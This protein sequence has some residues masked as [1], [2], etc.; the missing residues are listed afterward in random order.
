[1]LRAILMPRAR[2]LR[3]VAVQPPLRHHSNVH[4][5]IEYYDGQFDD[6]RYAL[7]LAQTAALHGASTLNHCAVERLLRDP[8][9]GASAAHA[10]RADACMMCDS[11]MPRLFAFASSLSC[12]AYTAQH[13]A[14]ISLP[15]PPEAENPVRRL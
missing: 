8:N 10:S 14:Q 4:V 1:M 2:G 11:G 15:T 9:T 7:A 3:A 6:A 13:W 5:Q 12:A